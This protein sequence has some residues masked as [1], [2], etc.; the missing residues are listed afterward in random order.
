SELLDAIWNDT[1][2]TEN[3]LTRVIAQLRK[4][5]G[6]DAKGSK[7]IETIPTMGYRFAADVSVIDLPAI[8]TD[9]A[10]GHEDSLAAAVTNSGSSA[11]NSQSSA[12][13]KEASR[14]KRS[15]QLKLIIP[16]AVLLLAGA[17]AI[18]HR[19]EKPALT[20]TTTISRNTQ[21]T[22]SSGLDIGPTFS[23]DGNF[24]AYSSDRTGNFEIYIKALTPGGREIQLTSGGSQNLEPAWSPDGK[25]IAYRSANHGIWVMPALGGVA[26][27]I[28][29]FGS[30]PSWSPDGSTIA[31][32]SVDPHDFG[33]TAP[34]ASPSSEV[35]T[36]AVKSGETTQITHPAQ[37]PGE[38]GAPVWS[39][40]GKRIIFCSYSDI[41]SIAIDGHNPIHL[42][43]HQEIHSLVYSPKEEGIYY[44]ASD[45]DRGFG[46]WKLLIN[47]VTGEAKGEPVLVTR[48]TSSSNG[49]S[50][51]PDGK[52]VA[53][54]VLRTLSNLV[55]VPVSATTSEATGS[56]V[57]LTHGTALR[58]F[59][60]AFSPDGKKIAFEQWSV[61]NNDSIWVIDSD[62]NNARQVTADTS[63]HNPSWFPDGKTLLF[64]SKKSGKDSFYSVTLDG[65][66][67]HLLL[68]PKAPFVVHADLSPDGKTVAFHTRKQGI[69][70]VWLS[71]LVD[72]QTK[73]ITFD[74]EGAGW[75]Y[76]SPDAKHMVVE[77]VR[78]EDS[79]L[80]TID[81]DG[82]TMTTVVAD[83][84]QSWSG[85]WSPDSSKILFSG[86]RDGLWNIWWVSPSTGEKKRL[87]D[88]K[89]LSEYVR[90]PVWSPV[91]NQVVYE[92]GETT[93]NVWIMDLK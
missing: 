7:Y 51:S 69:V 49:L 33:E 6:D 28:V 83:H 38:H 56:P 66:K 25:Q 52:R 37:P 79:L 43:S 29:N 12:L 26:R 19:F 63:N 39:T 80:S 81:A 31:F 45:A 13:L 20:E 88:Y 60:P 9:Q 92:H 8:R 16:A 54:S 72:G 46:L 22:T 70:N 93:G 40:D 11:V 90:Y 32:A 84:G 85:G 53:Y 50:I 91:G 55:S 21:I 44:V 76:W 61:G 82:G 57:Q 30:H 1:F 4:A 64:F 24:I 15:V 86:Q 89:L 47:S 3:A 17:L 62:G 58:N 65:E 71:S 41:R 5:I 10:A 35:W 14:K 67:A 42:A 27:Q 78:G 87:T 36:V 73:Q 77:I 2:V 18:W 68:T 74:K 34:A 75:V 59:F 48:L 23:P